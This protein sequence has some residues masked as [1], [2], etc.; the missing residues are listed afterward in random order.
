[1]SFGSGLRL[2]AG[3]RNLET[4]FAQFISHA[5]SR[6]GFVVFVPVRDRDIGQTLVSGFA[7]LPIAEFTELF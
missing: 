5:V 6:T 4:C 1:M 7:K 2:Y 3:S